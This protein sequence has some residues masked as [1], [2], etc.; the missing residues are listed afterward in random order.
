MLNEESKE[1]RGWVDICCA[2]SLLTRAMWRWRWWASLPFSYDAVCR[3]SLSSLQFQSHLVR[4]AIIMSVK[5]K[6]VNYWVYAFIAANCLLSVCVHWMN[7]MPDHLFS[8]YQPYDRAW[9]IVPFCHH[10]S[11]RAKHWMEECLAYLRSCLLAS[12]S[13]ATIHRWR[14]PR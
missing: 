4:C 14:S 11:F 5:R 12:F 2:A 8:F 1:A 7:S 9:R 6:S 10:R 3:R 13:A